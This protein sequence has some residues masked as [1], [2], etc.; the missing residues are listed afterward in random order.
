MTTAQEPFI[1]PAWL[2]TAALN[3]LSSFT[4]FWNLPGTPVDNVNHGRGGWSAVRRCCVRTSPDAIETVYVKRQVNYVSRTLRHPLS[5]E[6][7]A[8]REFRALQLLGQSGI[9]T[10][11][12]RYF[13]EEQQSRERRAILVTQALDEYESLDRLEAQALPGP[14]RRQHVC[15]AAALLRSIHDTGQRHNCFYPKHI[16]LRPLG[17]AL[18]PCVIDLEKLRWFPLQKAAAR[19]DIATLFNR[20]P[21]WTRPQRL[22]FLLAYFGSDHV[23]QSVRTMWQSLQRGRGRTQSRDALKPQEHR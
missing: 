9:G 1:D 13:A 12:I 5:G 22:R 18:R 8:A 23:D 16:F 7:T 3:G 20:C 21:H 17:A 6:T 11:R 2:R 19:R 10:P 15:A 14:V 4:D